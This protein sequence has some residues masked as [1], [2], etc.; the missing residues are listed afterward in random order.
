MQHDDL[1]KKAQ[2]RE[3]L[4]G[5]VVEHEE[6]KA[7]LLEAADIYITLSKVCA[8]GLAQTYVQRAK[9]CYVAS[10]QQPKKSYRPLIVEEKKLSFDDVAGLE[11]VKEKIRLKII[12]PF[13]HPD[14]YAYY[15]KKVG[16]GI[17]MY[18]PP[19]CGKTLI[20]EAAAHEAGC[21]FFVANVS[22]LTSKYVGETEKNISSLFAQAREAAP[23]IIFF[24]ELE[25]LGSE[26][27][28]AQEYARTA[29]SQLL[30]EINGLGN[31]DQRILLIGATNE[32]W[33]VDIA[34]RRAG[35]FGD[36]LFVPP[37]DFKTRYKLVKQYL[38]LKPVA[39]DVNGIAIAIETEGYSGADLVELCDNAI[40]IAL[41]DSLASKKPRQVTMDDF[42][43]VL[44]GKRAAT[45]NWF[46]MALQE[47][48]KDDTL[49]GEIM[50]HSRR[51]VA[52]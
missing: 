40:E 49:F 18:G 2:E 42:I 27:S 4:A 41:R 46:R 15:G 39:G 25:A 44:S 6:R 9:E 33:N 19:G 7:L 5:E 11:Q 17:L 20:A 22:N 31:R 47:L 36:P 26:R 23:S 21:S 29:V 50:Q 10:Q 32:P 16:G 12:E 1:L 3:L 43:A 45:V 34:L 52:I 13:R 51:L 30:V 28:T 48:K 37:P 8:A 24:D 14:L 35:R 38:T